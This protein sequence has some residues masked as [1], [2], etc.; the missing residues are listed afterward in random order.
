MENSQVGS[1]LVEAFKAAARRSKE[2]G[3]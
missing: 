2:L 1:N 3:V